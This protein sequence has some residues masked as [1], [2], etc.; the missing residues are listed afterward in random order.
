MTH[1][2]AFSPQIWGKRV[3]ILFKVKKKDCERSLIII[4]QLPG[5]IISNFCLTAWPWDLRPQ[6]IDFHFSQFYL[7]KGHY[8][9]L[10]IIMRG[11][12]HLLEATHAPYTNHISHQLIKNII[13]V[14]VDLISLNSAYEV[15]YNSGYYQINPLHTVT[16]YHVMYKTV[17]ALNSPSVDCCYIKA[18]AIRLICVP[19]L[20]QA[21]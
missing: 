13:T 18:W 5:F 4:L 12:L 8:S 3:W 1:S 9:T 16:N 17:R 14:C 10:T 20:A 6:W 7:Y 2:K 15:Q 19:A 21:A 11:D